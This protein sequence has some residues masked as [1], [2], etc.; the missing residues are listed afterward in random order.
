MLPAEGV[1]GT[2]KLPRGKVREGV[3]EIEPVL[4]KEELKEALGEPEV[5]DTGV[6]L[7]PLTPPLGEAAV[8][9]LPLPPFL[10]PMEAVAEMQTDAVGEEV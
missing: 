5:V 7:A 3:L 8:E 10:T 1:L 6:A 9:E 4:Q 2:L